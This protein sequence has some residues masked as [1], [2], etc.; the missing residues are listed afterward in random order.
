MD[1]IIGFP[2][3]IADY[4]YS[5][6]QITQVCKSLDQAKAAAIENCERT[7]RTVI[8]TEPDGYVRRY[9]CAPPFSPGNPTSKPRA[10]R[11]T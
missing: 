10:I 11:E 9:V 2:S 4:P 7:H 8:I 5:V 6:A 3:D 1:K